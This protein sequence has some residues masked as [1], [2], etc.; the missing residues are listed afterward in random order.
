MRNLGG[1]VVA[2]SRR[3]NHCNELAGPR[4]ADVE[5]VFAAVVTSA[6]G[7]SAFIN[8]IAMTIT[9]SQFRIAFRRGG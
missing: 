5:V 7:L 6:I 9:L 8:E 1:N 3:I 4:L 2:P